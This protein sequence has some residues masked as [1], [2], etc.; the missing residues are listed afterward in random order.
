MQKLRTGKED[1]MQG[2]VT[3]SPGLYE[4]VKARGHAAC[5][6]ARRASCKHCDRGREE[7]L[8][9]GHCASIC[10]SLSPLQ[11]AHL[12]D[13]IHAKQPSQLSRPSQE[14]VATGAR[15]G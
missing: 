2:L 5:D 1:V 15:L 4:G 10:D 3:P 7:D 9:G 12:H 8:E 13:D 11:D 6:Q 14:Q